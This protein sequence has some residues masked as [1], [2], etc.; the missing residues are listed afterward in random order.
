M[1]S[2]YMP[3]GMCVSF[4]RAL[5]FNPRTLTKHL[6]A[7]GSRL[8]N[9]EA[10]RSRLLPRLHVPLLRNRSFHNPTS[11]RESLLLSFTRIHFAHSPLAQTATPIIDLL[12]PNSAYITWKLY[13]ECTVSNKN[14]IVKVRPHLSS[15]CTPLPP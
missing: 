5:T 3:S 4:L 15:P 8:A 13:N 7:E 1:T 9:G 6:R 14:H 11:L 10:P 12:D 2:S